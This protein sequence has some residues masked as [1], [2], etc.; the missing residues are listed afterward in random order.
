MP[1]H[2]DTP[3][4]HW[5]RQEWD[6][7]NIGNDELVV[8]CGYEYA[9]ESVLIAIIL[10]E[11]LRLEKPRAE[12]F[13]RATEKHIA[14]KD[15]DRALL[16]YMKV[17]RLELYRRRHGHKSEHDWPPALRERVE[18]DFSAAV[19]LLSDLSDQ[20]H[21]VACCERDAEKIE[22]CSD[23]HLGAPGLR[24]LAKY[25]VADRPWLLIPKADRVNTI[26][27][28]RRHQFIFF[29]VVPLVESVDELE[30]KIRKGEA[31][32]VIYPGEEDVRLRIRNG[33]AGAIDESLVQWRKQHR[34][35]SKAAAAAG[36][37][38]SSWWLAMKELAAMRLLHFFSPEDAIKMFCDGYG[39]SSANIDGTYLWKLRRS[40]L[41]T[42]RQFFDTEEEP[43]R[44]KTWSNC[45]DK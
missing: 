15:V 44:A 36:G 39:A 33:S 28:A 42:F 41:S 30:E 6:F 29:R 2:P 21:E 8:A 19:K 3:G 35:R 7:S 17:V 4:L 27:G 24:F 16:N 25:F 40:S 23:G 10:K 43:C 9:R 12:L 18:R 32:P 26:A 14:L 37:R 11:W 22:S 20:F 34:T 1:R 13:Q 38:S 5:P 31:L 45:A